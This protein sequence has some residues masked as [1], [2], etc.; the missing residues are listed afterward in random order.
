MAQNEVVCDDRGRIVLPAEYRE[1]L[2]DHYYIS[3]SLG[4]ILLVPKPLDPIKD[5][6]VM[7]KKAGLDKMPLHKIKEEIRKAAAELI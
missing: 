7:G 2:G 1:Q 6:A 5:M 3:K 4:A